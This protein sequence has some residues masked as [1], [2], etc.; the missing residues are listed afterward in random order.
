MLKIIL[1]FYYKGQEAIKKGV[2]I[3][4]LFSMP[5]REKK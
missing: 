5:V 4:D 2:N 1:A 3:N